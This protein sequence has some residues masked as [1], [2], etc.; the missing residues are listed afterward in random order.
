VQAGAVAFAKLV[1]VL[2]VK[3]ALNTH[4]SLLRESSYVAILAGDLEI[5]SKKSSTRRH[6][7][8]TTEKP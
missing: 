7:F 5:G 8:V 2:A 4:V 3:W 1:T 6:N